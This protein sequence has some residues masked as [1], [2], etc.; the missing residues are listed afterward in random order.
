VISDFVRPRHPLHPIPSILLSALVMGV[1]LVFNEATSM[2]V[3]LGSLLVLFVLAGYGRVI[4]KV[5][6]LL[7]PIGLVVA[8]LAHFL[9]D[10]IQGSLMT[11][12]RIGLVGFTSVLVITIH[13]TRLSRAL[14]QVGCP[15]VIALALLVTVRFVPVLKG[16]M[17]RI[18]E[19]M[20]VRGVDFRWTNLQHAYRAS[21]L[22]LIVRLINI[23]DMLALSVETRGFSLEARGTVY[24]PVP[25]HCKDVLVSLAFVGLA[26]SA[27]FLT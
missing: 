2:Y 23:S 20:T 10:S 25:L 9:G 17:D 5:F 3:F 26:I 24:K 21:V 16:E 18:R 4:W 1:G 19:A 7:L 8:A 22:P 11:L 6:R 13:P 12:G 14:S 15:R 27:L